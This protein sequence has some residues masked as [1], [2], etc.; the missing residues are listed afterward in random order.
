[1]TW[2]FRDRTLIDSTSGRVETVAVASPV[3]WGRVPKWLTNRLAP[4]KLDLTCYTPAHPLLNGAEWLDHWGTTVEADGEE[5]FVSEPYQLTAE[6]M[7]SLMHLADALDLSVIVRASSAY[8]P[9]Y[10][11]RITLTPRVVNR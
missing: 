6:G 3:R 8:Y 9:T 5:A 2:E 7:R 1:M 11:L 10:S 4:H